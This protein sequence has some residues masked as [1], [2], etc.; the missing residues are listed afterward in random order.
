MAVPITILHQD[1]RLLVAAKPARMMT[2]A[3]P[4]GQAAAKGKPLLD[5]LLEEG[6]EVF[7]VHRLDYETSG[8]VLF[9]RDEAMRAALMAMFKERALRK[10]YLALVQGR[11]E[12][13][14]GSIDLPIKDLGAGARIDRRGSPA[15]TRWEKERDIGPCSLVRAQPET[16]RHNQIRLHFAAIGH[17]LVGERKFAQGKNDP[18]GH[19]RVM[20]HALGL[21]FRPPHLDHDLKLRCEPPEDFQLCLERA[22]SLGAGDETRARSPRN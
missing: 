14:A 18:V 22:E 6:H 5:R 3:A 8:I 17:P 9:A 13:A 15:L 12:R 10:T 16:G 1:R 21:R 7:A 4:G 19:K 20:L 11:L 2:V